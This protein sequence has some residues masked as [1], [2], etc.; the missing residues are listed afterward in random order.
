M[1]KFYL[2]T[3]IYYVNARPHIGHTYTTVVADTITR[4]KRMRGYQVVLLT[5]T[6]EHGETVQRSARKAG[7]EPKAFADEVTAA[8]QRLWQLL[9]LDYDH[10]VR[11][12][13]DRHA[14]AVRTL[15]A[16]VKK[17]GYI[18]KGAY[19]G[20][21]CVPDEMYVT[22]P[23]PEGN[24]PS[25]GRPTERIEEENYYFKLS[26]FEEQLLQHYQEHPEF[27]QPE[28]RRNEVLSFVR[29]GLRDLSI[30][31]T[32]F[33][34]GIPV[35]GAEDHVFYV[36][37]DALTSYISGIGYGAAGAAANEFNRLWP[38]DLHLVGK[39]IVR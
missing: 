19:Q 1:P 38:A 30:S 22:D 9:G 33:R 23:T 24:C 2:T 11:T 13:S 16:A 7:K 39:E 34:W 31:R 20:Q 35:P 32:R 4:Y 10:F 14:E 8:Y 37:F 3:P 29:G 12:T 18:Y 6:D 28:T 17:A 5:G 15:F 27:I 25:C 21:Y 26:A 36:W